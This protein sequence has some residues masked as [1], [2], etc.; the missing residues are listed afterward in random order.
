MPATFRHRRDV[1]TSDGAVPPACPPDGRAPLGPGAEAIARRF[2]G[3]AT[4][5][6]GTALRAMFRLIIC[7]RQLSSVLAGYIVYSKRGAPIK[8]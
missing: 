2:R 4:V 8:L 7:A 1:A 5:G 6:Q 3:A